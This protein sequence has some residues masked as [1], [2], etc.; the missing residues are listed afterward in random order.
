L[1]GLKV[2]RINVTPHNWIRSLFR[3]VEYRSFLNLLKYDEAYEAYAAMYGENKVLVYPYEKVQQNWSSFIEELANI[4]GIDVEVAISLT[5]DERYNTKFVPTFG[6]LLKRGNLRRKYTLIQLIYN[7]WLN[8]GSLFDEGVKND[9]RD[10][11]RES[12][13]R[14]ATTLKEDLALYGYAL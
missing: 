9:L 12:N 8:K 7:R 14:F 13:R 6:S 4:L 5:K 3:N 2:G 1:Q 10:F 11:F